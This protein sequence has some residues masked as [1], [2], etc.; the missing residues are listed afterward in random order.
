L[1]DV[2]DNLI[3]H[4]KR[5]DFDLVNLSR[6]KINDHFD[7][8]MAIDVSPFKVDHLSDPSKPRQEDWFDLVGVLVHQGSSE[9]GHYYSYI[10]SRPT[11]EHAT[12]WNEFND[13]DVD[14]FDPQYIA[15]RAFGGFTDQFQ[16]LL[17]NYSAYMLFYQRRSAIEKDHT[18]YSNSLQS[19]I[20]K[21]PV[22]P[23]MEQEISVDNEHCIRE[24]SLYDPHHTKF[25]RQ[26]LANVRKINHG[27][28][29]ED[30][31]LETQ[32]LHIALEH[33]FLVHIRVRTPNNFEETLLQLR[34]SALSC[35]VCCLVVLRWLADRESALLNMLILCEEPKSR[36]QSRAFVVD[37]LRYLREI[38]PA[39]YSSDL[40]EADSDTEA[41]APSQGILHV[42]VEQLR[43]VAEYSY[44]SVRSWDDFYLTLCQ[45]N[46]MGHIETSVLLSNS[47]LRF[48]LEVFCMPSLQMLQQQ[49]LEMWRA[50]EK[51]RRIYNRMVEFVY[52]LLSKMEFGEHA[53]RI[54]AQN[55]FINRLDTYDRNLSKFP[56]TSEEQFVLL[57]WYE[58][59]KAYAALDRMLE[60]FDVSKTEVFYPGE[61]LKWMM[62]WP[63]IHTRLHITVCEGILQLEPP[64]S[65]PYVR[66]GLRFC[67]TSPN[68]QHVDKVVKIVANSA[69]RSEKHGGEA[70]LEFFIGLLHT[71]NEAFFESKGADWFFSLSLD[72][73]MK[74]AVPLLM[75]EN[76]LVRQAA[77]RHLENLFTVWKAD[78][79]LGID[80]E[81][82]VRKYETIRSLAQVLIRKVE[83]ERRIGMLRSYM[84]PMIS[85]CSMLI[86]AL[87]QLQTNEDPAFDQYKLG[88]D[89][90]LIQYHAEL[91]VLLGNWSFD[92]GTPQSLE[93]G[94]DH[95][96]YGSESEVDAD[97]LEI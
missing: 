60:N 20:V 50:T 15:S 67:Q 21:V 39:A 43:T 78:Q 97:L 73:A 26:A 85:T 1:K 57:H 72:A 41:L 66:A 56:L 58:E 80:E 11:P 87:D 48:C 30:H 33:L 37:C 79:L 28:C 69:T 14:A 19:G 59:N 74:I 40:I 53:P 91:E 45:I 84:Q 3:F 62:Q 93:E 12:Q 8:P 63:R 65:D 76:D 25:V 82:L 49:R 22:S 2:P 51:R 32:A 95:S 89:I 6:A 7:F 17:K 68:V 34:K 55:N 92:E 70:H 54:N 94:F 18:E 86:L 38:E 81:I 36:S 13:K 83:E 90:N 23:A 4:L 44:L 64:S 35:S 24:Y 10:R 88:S 46:D 42:L 96:D 16:R 29:S 31:V 61:I 47:F 5:F 77:A 27:T 9:A 75:Y 52:S 71:E